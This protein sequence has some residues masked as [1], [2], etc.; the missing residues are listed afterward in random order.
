[1][2]RRQ[3]SLLLLLQV[4]ICCLL[5]QMSCN[6]GD[7]T[8]DSS[9]TETSQEDAGSHDADVSDA[10][11]AIARPDGWT[12]ETHSA[13]ALP[14]YDI[15]FPQDAVNRIDIAI[16]AGDWVAM[17]DDIAM[18]CG[19]FGAAK[20]MSSIP[21]EA[22]EACEGKNLE[23]P[24]VVYYQGSEIEGICDQYDE[25][26][27][28]CAR[29]Y[30]LPDGYVAPDLVPYKPVWVP[31]TVTFGD[32][33]W[34]HVGIRLKGNSTLFNTWMGGI[35]KLPF[36]LDFD[37][38]ELEHPEI[39]DQRFYGFKRLSLCNNASDPSLLR[40]KVAG[41]IFRASGVPAPWRAFYRVY[42]NVGEGPV[43]F[44]LYTIGEVPDKPMLKTQFGNADGNLYKPDGYGARWTLEDFDEGW[45]P[46]KL[47][48]VAADWSD[49]EAAI[50]ALN[51]SR[52]DPA[53][54]RAS[55]EETFNVDHFLNWLAINTVIQD[56]DTYGIFSHNYYLYGDSD[57]GGRLQ[58]IPWD[59]NLS[60]YDI[61]GMLSIGLTEVSENWPLIRFLMDDSVYRDFYFQY[62][63]AV[64]AGAFDVE[65]FQTRIQAEHD[66]IRPY[67]VGADGE[68]PDYTHLP[69]PA[70]F[71]LS[72]EYLMQ[73]VID[74]HQA[75]EDALS[76][77]SNE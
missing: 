37:E 57:D 1:M 19:E 22:L 43:Y 30:P 32:K 68:L 21:P 17:Q 39:E 33:T 40:D 50:V 38:F 64:V 46:K 9:D 56:W 54:W 62:V 34:W 10:G 29:K 58:W 8:G 44:G 70:Y 6:G 16:F 36:K 23:E 45:F 47:N 72:L 28:Y 66:L 11:Q 12:E 51:A 26:V 65:A 53:A 48:E 31:C 75:V 7:G 60:M 3:I 25:D 59:H 76:A 4:T 74:R 41:D 15:V 5:V 20:G 63:E 14:N 24:C 13:D 2:I 55:L 77:R 71:D 67:V 52:E 69:K 42:I 61:R 18:Q 27:L 73:H 35:Y 49:I